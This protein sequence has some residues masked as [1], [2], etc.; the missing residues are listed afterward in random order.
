LWMCPSTYGELLELTSPLYRE[1]IPTWFLRNKTQTCLKNVK[2]LHKESNH[3][4]H[5]Q[6]LCAH[7]LLRKLFDCVWGPLR[8]QWLT[9]SYVLL[10][11]VETRSATYPASYTVV[12][13]G[14]SHEVN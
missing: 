1:K 3:T 11:N 10:Q 5:G 8:F 9:Q 12:T 4:T 7:K 13:G 6:T 14:F 2:L